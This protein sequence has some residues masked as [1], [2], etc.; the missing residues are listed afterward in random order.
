[1]FWAITAGLNLYDDIKKKRSESRD[2]QSDFRKAL[3][4]KYVEI[5]GALGNV[6]FEVIKHKEPPWWRHVFAFLQ[7]DTGKALVSALGF[8]AVTQQ[9]IRFVDEATS[10]LDDTKP[11]VLFR[12]CPLTFAFS[13]QAK[14]D[15]IG[16]GPIRIGCL[17]QGTWI[18]ARGRDF[19]ALA[20][21]KAY[22]YATYG[23]LV[24][25]SVSPADLVTGSYDDPFKN[26]TYAIFRVLMKP[27]KLDVSFS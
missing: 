2:L 10:R 26:V 5:P 9:V 12:S 18:F 11:E 25:S 22:F 24:P 8:P 27:Y 21:A 4:N 3:G 17:N 13:K 14:S 1:L 23:K 16:N 7:T 6:T 20:N 19:R 15:F